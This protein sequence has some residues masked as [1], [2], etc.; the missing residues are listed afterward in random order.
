MA[1][2]IEEGKGRLKEAIGAVTGS[3]SVKR[4]GRAQQDKAEAQE[5]AA[6]HE[7]RAEAA[8]SDASKAQSAESRHQ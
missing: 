2:P 1:N 7:E 6:R 8:A 3:S 4:E 5:E